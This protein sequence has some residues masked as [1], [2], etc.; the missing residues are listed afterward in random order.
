MGLI[1]SFLPSLGVKKPL[2]FPREQ[3]NRLTK[4]CTG[5]FVHVLMEIGE[6]IT[7]ITAHTHFDILHS[8]TNIGNANCI[9]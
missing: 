6:A 3:Y 2:T 7:T 5:V 9:V 1:L 4:N 8:T